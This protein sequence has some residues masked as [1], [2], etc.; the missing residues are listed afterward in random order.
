MRNL[1]FISICC[2]TAHYAR[3]QLWSVSYH[4]N[5]VYKDVERTYCEL[6]GHQARHTECKSYIVRTSSLALPEE[7]LQEIYKE[8]REDCNEVEERQAEFDPG[9]DGE[10]QLEP[11]P[12]IGPE[13]EEEEQGH[14]TGEQDGEHLRLQSKVPSIIMSSRS[15]VEAQR[16]E[17][18]NI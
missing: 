14:G 13:K 3:H 7:T 16:D 17:R 2:N 1:K 11:P 12:T 4:H 9:H 10:L 6:H 8:A 5:W 15:T 18:K